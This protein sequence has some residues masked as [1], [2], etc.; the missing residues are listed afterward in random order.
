MTLMSLCNNE[1]V[2]MRYDFEQ[3]LYLSVGR[4]DAPVMCCDNWFYN[5]GILVVNGHIAI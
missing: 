4:N 3:F 5:V 1:N 2:K